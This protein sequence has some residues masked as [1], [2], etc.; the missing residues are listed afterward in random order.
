MMVQNNVKSQELNQSLSWCKKS[1]VGSVPGCRANSQGYLS[2]KN[3][4]YVRSQLSQKNLRL[5][6]RWGQDSIRGEKKLRCTLQQVTQEYTA[7]DYSPFICKER[8]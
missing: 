6:K 2:C 1:L 7:L 8:K 5:H 4:C 3:I